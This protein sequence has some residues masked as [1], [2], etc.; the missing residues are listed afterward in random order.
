MKTI[1]LAEDPARFAQLRSDYQAALNWAVASNNAA[2]TLPAPDTD[3]KGAG[4]ALTGASRD[5][6]LHTTF[7]GTNEGLDAFAD[8]DLTSAARPAPT[9]RHSLLA[10]YNP[11]ADPTSSN[12]VL[13]LSIYRVDWPEI[14]P[15][16]SQVRRKRSCISLD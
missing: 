2:A 14:G 6:Q 4:I 1:D 10:H 15:D 12:E 9:V 7:N 3:A 5:V 13:R 16:S 8:A 11:L